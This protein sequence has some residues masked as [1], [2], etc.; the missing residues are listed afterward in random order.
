MN[1]HDASGRVVPEN[2]EAEQALLGAILLNNAAF[3]VVNR[4]LEPQHFY[5]PLHQL[6]YEVI[7]Q[8]LAAGRGAN[9]VMLK[10]SLPAKVDGLKINGQEVS[11]PSYLAQLCT[12]AVTVI[13]APD[14][15][16]AVFDAWVARQAIGAL[17][18]GVDTY[19]KLAPGENPLKAFEPI[20]ERIASIRAEALKSSPIKSAGQSYLDSLSASYRRGEV[21]GVPIALEEIATVISEP[22]FEAGNLYG[23]LSSSAEGKT[24]LTVQLMR[25][26]LQRGNPVLMLS[27]DQSAEQIVR[28]MVAQE[29]EIEARRQRDA[30]LLSEKEFETCMAFASQL[31]T[32]PFRIVKCTDQTAPKLVRLAQTFVKQK[33]NGRVPL[34]VVDHI[35]SITPESDRGDEGTKALRI[36]Q[37]LKVGAEQTD[38]SWLVLNQRNSWGMKRPNPRPIAADLFGGEGAKAPFDAVFYLYRFLKFLEERKAIASK[39]SDWKEIERVFPSA[40]RNDGIDISEIGAVK[41]RFGSTNIRQRL[42]FEGRL[43]RYKSDRAPVEQESLEGF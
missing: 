12:H 1:T 20:E 17:Q 37:I 25:Y 19:F 11:V 13:N 16:A 35:R 23:L 7:G 27:F 28:Q 38:S 29:H 43:T 40:V 34:V 41:V 42:I 2:V 4:L 30:K 18:E 39:D 3:D 14:Y 22:C 31:D 10:N 24:S 15:A 9:P 6:V 36:G 33:G 32:M 26:A 21:R 8:T 5:E